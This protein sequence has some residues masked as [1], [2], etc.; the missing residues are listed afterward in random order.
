M[1]IVAY[2]VSHYIVYDWCVLRKEVKWV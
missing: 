1:F 2:L